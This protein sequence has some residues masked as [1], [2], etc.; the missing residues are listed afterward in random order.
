MESSSSSPTPR[1]GD[2]VS[3]LLD[4]LEAD[5]D[6]ASV[7]D[8]VREF[9]WSGQSPSARGLLE[10]AASAFLACGASSA[11]PLEFDQL[12]RR[13]LPEWPAR[14]NT[15]HQK[16]RYALQAAI[17]L[18]SGVEPEDTSWWRSNDLWSHAFD[19]VIVFVR[20]ASE[21]R[22]VPIAAICTALRTDD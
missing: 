4:G 6:L 12:E 1:A 17:L 14:G 13:Y 16:R 20:A 11:D 10:L 15:A 8:A 19:A 22:Q 7:H 9:F 3:V 21:R 2:P 5:E 18:S